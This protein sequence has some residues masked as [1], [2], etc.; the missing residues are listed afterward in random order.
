MKVVA[1]SPSQVIETQYTNHM[2]RKK[3]GS[4]SH[5]FVTTRSM[6]SE[7]LS[8]SE[9][10]CRQ[11]P[12]SLR[13]YSY[14]PLVMML[15]ES[16]SSSFSQAAT[17]AS[18]FAATSEGR[19]T[20]ERTFSSRSN[21]LMEY[22]RSRSLSIYGSARPRISSSA[23][24][25]LPLKIRCTGT[26]LRCLATCIARSAASCEPVPLSAEVSITSH[27]RAAES[28]WTSIL[29]PLFLTTSIM[30]SAI[31]TGAFISSTCVVR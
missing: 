2:M 5:R 1:I 19:C 12:I 10:L 3:I 17:T 29:S 30:F 9:R 18:I 27:P 16:S 14:R 8:C 7:T 24:S 26:F 22:H 20:S 4:A 11:L 28:F 31:T 13:I 21:S 15:S 23:C 6:R 25:T